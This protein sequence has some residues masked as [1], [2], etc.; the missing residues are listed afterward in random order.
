MD[1]F[2]QIFEYHV[3]G[4]KLSSR[5]GKQ[6]SW[7]TG[8]YACYDNLRRSYFPICRKEWTKLT[9]LIVII[10]RLIRY[11][12]LTV[13]NGRNI[14]LW[15]W[16]LCMQNA[17]KT[18]KRRNLY[19]LY[20]PVW[21]RFCS[22]SMICCKLSVKSFFLCCLS[23]P[24]YRKISKWGELNSDSHLLKWKLPITIVNLLG[25]KCD[26]FVISYSLLDKRQ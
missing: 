10:R 24:T 17:C 13:S 15:R 23:L 3:A 19:F 8:A 21:A 14:K 16:R 2:K 7:L 11:V 1:I 9:K 18:L 20:E 5:F 22:F 12:I 25:N 4:R 6:I 26:I